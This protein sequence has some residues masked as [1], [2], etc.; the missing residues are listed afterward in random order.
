M[1]GE[2]GAAASRTLK[3]MSRGLLVRQ[4]GTRRQT[5]RRT[6]PP[7]RLKRANIESPPNTPAAKMGDRLR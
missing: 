1:P 3:V 5:L 6:D 2:R 7:V 4:R